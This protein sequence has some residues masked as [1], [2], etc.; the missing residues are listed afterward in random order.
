MYLLKFLNFSMVSRYSPPLVTFAL[1]AILGS[2]KT[3]TGSLRRHSCLLINP[4]I[5][6]TNQTCWIRT[7]FLSTMKAKTVLKAVLSVEQDEGVGARVRRSVGRPEV[8]HI[9]RDIVN[10]LRDEW[11]T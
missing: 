6:Q 11:K 3:T 8:R 2:C 1:S 10:Y 7:Q 9:L 4:L 5:H